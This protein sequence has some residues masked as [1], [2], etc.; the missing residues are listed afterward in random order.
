MLDS[1]GQAPSPA[2]GHSTAML[3]PAS[4]QSSLDLDLLFQPRRRALHALQT[5]QV[6][7]QRHPIVL[8]PRI[9]HL[10][11]DVLHALGRGP[12]QS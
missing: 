12:V 1:R 4:V 2:P 8:D 6:V 10:I 9:P 3:H 11:C 5:A 7:N